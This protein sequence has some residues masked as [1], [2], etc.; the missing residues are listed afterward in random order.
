M[1]YFLGLHLSSFKLFF[2][3]LSTT[4]RPNLKSLLFYGYMISDFH[5]SVLEY[6]GDAIGHSTHSLL[7][8]FTSRSGA[9]WGETKLQAWF[10]RNDQLR[11]GRT[12]P[13]RK[14]VNEGARVP[15]FHDPAFRKRKKPWKS[16]TCWQNSTVGW[17]KS[18]SD[19]AFNLSSFYSISACF[20]SFFYCILPFLLVRVKMCCKDRV[21]Y[22]FEIMLRSAL[23]WVCLRA[24]L[25]SL[26]SADYSI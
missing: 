15:E 22:F 6:R 5:K 14:L 13:K 25:F 20:E 2:S 4:F 10:V 11:Q 19:K 17:S 26:Y 21:P 9:L 24:A 16:L 23:L 18:I 8:C 12:W 3:C 7:K 1:K